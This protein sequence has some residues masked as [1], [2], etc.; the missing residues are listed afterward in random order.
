MGPERSMRAAK[1]ASRVVQVNTDEVK[2]LYEQYVL[3]T[4]AQVPLCLVKGKGTQVWDIQGKMYL[5]F[6]SGW[7]VSGLGHCHPDVVNAVKNQTRQLA[8]R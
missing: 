8:R 4:Y 6:F 5:D 2:Q 1:K 3:P 7:A